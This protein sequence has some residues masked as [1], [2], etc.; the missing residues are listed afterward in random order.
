[1]QREL[2]QEEIQLDIQ[3]FDRQIEEAEKAL[4]KL[5]RQRDLL[6]DAAIV[7]RLSYDARRQAA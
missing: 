3:H 4:T 5:R 6:A 2:S 7:Y 1:M